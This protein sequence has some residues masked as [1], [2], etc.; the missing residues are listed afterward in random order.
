[1]DSISSGA[2]GPRYP[3]FGAATMRTSVFEMVGLIDASLANYEDYEWFTRARDLGAQVVSHD[4]VVQVRHIHADSTSRLNPPRPHD[5]LAV[6]Q[7][8]V[9]RRR[10]TSLAAPGVAAQ[11]G[12]DIPYG[13]DGDDPR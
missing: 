4:R 2:T 13:H 3:H 6:I 12:A 1:M 10:G 9:V 11:Q 7:R 8:S 5:L